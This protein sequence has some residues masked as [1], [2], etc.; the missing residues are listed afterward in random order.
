MDFRHILAVSWLTRYC[1]N[2]LKAGISLSRKYNAKLSIVHVMDTTWL[3]G[4]NLPM[5]SIAEELAKDM[6]RHKTELHKIIGAEQK[7]G[8][9]IDEIVREGIPSQVIL[10][11]IKEAQIDLLVLRSH[12]E[13]L[14]ERFLVGGS[15]DDIIRAM[16]CSIFLVK[17]ETCEVEANSSACL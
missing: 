1:D 17:P 4:W 2:T 13:S 12:E 5:V 7:K 16:P 6:E 15:N 8:M 10:Q 14:I 9:N 11:L 3:K